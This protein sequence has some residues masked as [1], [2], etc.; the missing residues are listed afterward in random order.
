MGVVGKKRKGRLHTLSLR[1]SFYGVLSS[2]V[3][4]E[5]LHEL[6]ISRRY[7]SAFFSRAFFRVDNRTYFE[8]YCT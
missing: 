8:I 5:Q 4:A 1:A 2:T 3:T 7:G 6:R